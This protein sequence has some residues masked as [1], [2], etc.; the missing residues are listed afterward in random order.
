MPRCHHST[1]SLVRLMF[2][3]IQRVVQIL[4]YH[5]SLICHD[6]FGFD[7]ATSPMTFLFP[8]K[9]SL[10]HLKDCRT[11]WL[12]G[13]KNLYTDASSICRVSLG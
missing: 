9:G 3:D 1:L 8:L 10:S 13:D 12:M 4:G 6:R 11:F 5:E 7:Y 2:G